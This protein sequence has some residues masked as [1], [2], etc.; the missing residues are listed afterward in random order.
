[1][2]T[3]EILVSKVDWLWRSKG[4]VAGVCV[5]EVLLWWGSCEK[6]GYKGYSKHISF[7]CKL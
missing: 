2:I 5:S 7:P 6:N 4:S 1:M 3:T